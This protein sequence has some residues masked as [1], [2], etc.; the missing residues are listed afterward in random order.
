MSLITITYRIYLHNFLCICADIL[1][2]NV[3]EGFC[4]VTAPAGGNKGGPVG[5]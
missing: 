3:G 4:C 2:W 1:P 5:F